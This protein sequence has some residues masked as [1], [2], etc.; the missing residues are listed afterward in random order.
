MRVLITS[1]NS[2]SYSL[3]GSGS[4]DF[5]IHQ[6]SGVVTLSQALDYESRSSYSLTVAA[7]DSKGGL[8]TTSLT[9]TVTN[10]NDAPVS[11][12]SSYSASIDENVAVGTNVL[13]TS[14]TDQDGD[15]VTYSIAGKG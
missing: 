12:S 11:I 10:S 4:S 8:A 5:S 3:S 1:G 13:Q 9:V 14:A 15:T 2:V 7:S 6:S